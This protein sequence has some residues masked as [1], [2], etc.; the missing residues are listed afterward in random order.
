MAIV[1]HASKLVMA[2][3]IAEALGQCPEGNIVIGPPA[4]RTFSGK[5]EVGGDST[6]YVL[7]DD[8]PDRP[9]STG[10]HILAGCSATGDPAVDPDVELRLANEASAFVLEQDPGR[11]DSK[12]LQLRPAVGYPD[13]LALPQ[14]LDI[15]VQAC[16]PSAEVCTTSASKMV[17]ISIEIF[18]VNPPQFNR[19]FGHGKLDLSSCPERSICDIPVV[20]EKQITANDGDG[21]V[22]IEFSHDRFTPNAALFSTS[23]SNS[24]LL[25][26]YIGTQSSFSS[27]NTTVVLM[28]QAK[29][30]RPDA[31]MTT[32]PVMVTVSGVTEFTTTTTEDP[33][34]AGGAC[35]EDLERKYFISMIVLGACLGGLLTALFIVLLCLCCKRIC[36]LCGG[37]G[38]TDFSASS[39]NV[40]MRQSGVMAEGAAFRSFKDTTYLTLQEHHSPIGSTTDSPRVGYEPRTRYSDSE[41]TASADGGW[42]KRS[43]N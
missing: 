3:L 4:D 10:I 35:D 24:E 42:R 32:I 11:L 31:L 33:G 23:S 26:N 41:S 30:Q 20:L 29:E 13:L 39:T 7:L 19:Y 43:K 18:N 34:G 14:F 1:W 27:E 16:S 9:G 17:S 37:S 8:N 36:G 6:K 12:I 21:Q 40:S 28:V 5:V 25:L 15:A 38:S 22:G 2:C